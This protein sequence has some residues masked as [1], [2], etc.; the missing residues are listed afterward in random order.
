MLESARKA[1]EVI[2]R[3]RETQKQ[4]TADRRELVANV[5][6]TFGQI[7]LDIMRPVDAREFPNPYDVVVQPR[8]NFCS[9]PFET[10]E[11]VH[12]HERF[13]GHGQE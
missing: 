12:E 1:I 7:L 13:S 8:C 3:L 6:P 2:D 11:E 9:R 10:L 5:H 4:F